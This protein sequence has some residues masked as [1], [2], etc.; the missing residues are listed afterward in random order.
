MYPSSNYYLCHATKLDYDRAFAEARAFALANLDEKPSFTAD[1]YF[2]KRE[3]LRQSI[4][5]AKN[6]KVRNPQGL[7][8]EHGG[9]NKI[10]LEWQEE[11]IR[12]YCYEQ[13]EGGNGA[14][15]DMVIGAITHLRSVMPLSEFSYLFL[16]SAE[17]ESSSAALPAPSR[18]WFT[19]WLKKNTQLHTIH[20]KP[21]GRSL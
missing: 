16:I 21:C 11:A 19:A 10:L 1:V 5:R 20:T 17:N 2:V 13:W 7:Y 12:Q 6:K 9:N 14:T 3:A 8:N 18:R 4:A 15:F